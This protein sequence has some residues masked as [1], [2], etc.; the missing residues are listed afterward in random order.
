MVSFL[1]AFLYIFFFFAF[2]VENVKTFL[3][4]TI[5]G[6]KQNT[7]L[8][9]TVFVVLQQLLFQFSI[10]SHTHTPTVSHLLR[11]RTRTGAKWLSDY[12]FAYAACS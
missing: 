6:E 3:V 10:L 9:F 5:G 12:L 4:S 11:P 1:V 7:K 2:N 8:F